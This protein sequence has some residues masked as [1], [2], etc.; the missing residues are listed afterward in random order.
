MKLFTPDT[1]KQR[2]QQLKDT[3]QGGVVLLVGNEESSMNFGD[4]W[5]HYRQ[6]STFPACMA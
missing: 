4:N 1:Y 6:D 5:Y 3:L 2:R